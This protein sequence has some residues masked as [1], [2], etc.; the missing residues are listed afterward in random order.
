ME[1]KQHHVKTGEKTH[2]QP[3]SI[4]LL[5]RRDKKVSPA[6]SV[7]RVSQTNTVSRDT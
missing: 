6:L 1:E 7:E 5:K 3:E 2:S 4:Y